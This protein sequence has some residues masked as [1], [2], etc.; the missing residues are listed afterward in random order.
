MNT[1]I[2]DIYVTMTVFRHPDSFSKHDDYQKRM[3]YLYTS[4]VIIKFI[5]Y[6]RFKPVLHSKEWTR[7]ENL[8]FIE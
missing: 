2:K 5:L 4:E 1:F 8:Y 6:W 3:L 7:Q